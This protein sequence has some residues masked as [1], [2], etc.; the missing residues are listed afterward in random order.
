LTG[1]KKEIIA[2]LTI[3]GKNFEI[4]VYDNKVW[5][6][7]EGKI[8]DIKEVLVGNIIYTNIRKG[9]KASL[10]DLKKIFGTNDIYIIAD[11]I[12]KNG[13][14]QITSEQR[15]KLIEEKKRRIIDFISK[16]CVDP[17]T[18]LPHPP[19]RIEMALK[20]A[21]IG[22]DPFK[23]VELQVNS[24]IKELQKILPLKISKAI[25]GIVIPPQ[26]IGKVYSYIH[27]SG[28]I[29]RSDYLSNGSWS[30]ELEIPA[31]LQGKIIE[32][33]NRLTRGNVRIKRIG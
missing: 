12:I 28:K 33:L 15:K 24:I 23:P 9:E 10:E 11:K 6:Y 25:M 32:D 27:N 5:E 21:R 14:I 20:E 16:N 31:G 22:I 7:K 8:K 29:L 4:L 30:I 13:E 18:N 1:K 19:L 26:F 17:R 2:R 3:H